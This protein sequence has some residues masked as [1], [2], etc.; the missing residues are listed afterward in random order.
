MERYGSKRTVRR[1][2]EI[3]PTNFRVETVLEAMAVMCAQC[4]WL[5]LTLPEVFE[6]VEEDEA[7]RGMEVDV[8]RCEL[9]IHGGIL[10]GW[11]AVPEL[12]DW[13]AS[14]VLSTRGFGFSLSKGR[15]P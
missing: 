1:P 13:L 5:R 3:D 7:D 9:H 11:R 15:L 2:S 4:S 10:A 6:V 12:S 8:E 14:S